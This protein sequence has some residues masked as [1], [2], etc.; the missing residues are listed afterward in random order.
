LRWEDIERILLAF[1]DNE[2]EDRE[3]KIQS[4]ILKRVKEI[5]INEEEIF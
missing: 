5:D 2:E 1:K 3:S 4:K